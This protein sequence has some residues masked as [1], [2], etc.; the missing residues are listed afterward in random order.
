MK[1]IKYSL[2]AAIV[3]G[4]FSVGSLHAQQQRA[5]PNIMVILIDDVGYSDIG[6]FGSE[7][8]T[9]NLDKL[10][11]GGVKMT[12]FYNN[13]RCC[14]T[15]AT[16]L[17][18]LYPHNAGIGWMTGT[19]MGEP[20]YIGELNQNCVTLAQ[21]LKP[22][23]YDT[24]ATGKWH[25]AANTNNYA[26]PKYNWPLQRG[27]DRYF[28][29]VPGGASY[30][31]PKALTSGNNNVKPG[32]GFYL[33]DA[34]ADTTVKYIHEQAPKKDP[35]FMYVAFTAA[36]W[37]LHAKPEDIKKY[38]GKYLTGWDNIRKTRY[39][40]QQAMGLFDKSVKFN[41]RD[42]DVPA[43]ESIPEG[44]RALW[45]KRMA[46]YAAQIDC[47]D[48]GV[49]RIIKALKETGQYDNTFIIFLSDNGACAEFIDRTKG[50]IEELG[51][52]KSY[53]SYRINW[54]NASNTPFKLYKHWVHEGGISAPCV[55]SWPK[56][57]AHPGTIINTPTHI[58]D[59]MPTFMELSGA[60]Y[61]T[62]FNG[63]DIH[64]LLGRSFI[65]LLKGNVMPDRTIFWEHEA[66]R[67]VRT[68]EWKLVSKGKTTP[69]YTTPW[70]LY[71]MANDRAE[72]NNLA[73]KYPDRVKDM[74]AQWDK[75]AAA[76]NVLPLNGLPGGKRKGKAQAKGGAED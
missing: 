37:P 34:I 56:H 22:A 70:E 76:N 75:W 58:M 53:E 28:G 10:A 15:R 13:A 29:I 33:T 57:L 42:A 23:G 16:L 68:N 64:P 17:T 44:D 43:W 2:L 11:Q 31:A 55:V 60:T 54:A 65:P 71:N 72:T 66:N 21:V 8:A 59:V 41:E 24:Y 4:V 48:Q 30:F 67:A 18:G 36:H 7:I 49:G 12:Q 51:T 9:P 20:G 63:K 39:A 69:P 3:A 32:K 27:F 25:V 62:T 52:N 40:K 5:K 50:P 19:N 73:A 61:P 74:A 45:A 6:C 47:M 1:Y 35:F 14:P 38:E 26:G 46:I